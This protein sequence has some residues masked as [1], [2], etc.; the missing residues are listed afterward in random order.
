MPNGAGRCCVGPL[1]DFR[2]LLE[3]SLHLQGGSVTLI[4]PALMRNGAGADLCE[5][6]YHS[7]DP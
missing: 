7:L 5:L 1:W 2:V 3:V 6:L 4:I